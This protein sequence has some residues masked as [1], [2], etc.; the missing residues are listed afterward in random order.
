M[1]GGQSA[2]TLTVT[3]AMRNELSPVLFQGL[4]K[5]VGEV[6]TITAN[7][8]RMPETDGGFYSEA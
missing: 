8:S 6:C 4:R 2:V 1:E 5:R 3:T 7:D